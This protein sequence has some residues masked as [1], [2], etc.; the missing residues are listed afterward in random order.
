MERVGQIILSPT[1]MQ[2]PIERRSRRTIMSEFYNTILYQPLFNATI[3]L[4]NLI[5]GD[6]FGLAIIALTI[7][8]R[9]IFF[10]LTVKSTQ[11][12]KAL[13]TINPKIQE[14]KERHKNNA[15]AQSA[16]IMQ[17]YKDNKI[18]PLAGCLPLLIQLPILIAL[19]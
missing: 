12:Q 15:Q 14:I 10:P 16:A 9:I 11:S 3:F 18:N 6:D 2:S 5:P 17:L 8:I 13:A 7:F 4:Y 1:K 19:Y